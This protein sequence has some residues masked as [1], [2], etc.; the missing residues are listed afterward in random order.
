MG[1]IALRDPT[2]NR[3]IHFTNFHR[4]RAARRADGTADGQGQPVRPAAGQRWRDHHRS[5]TVTS[6]GPRPGADVP[7]FYLTDAAG[8]KRMRLLA[9]E[10][11]ELRPGESRRMTVSAAPRLLARF[12]SAA[13]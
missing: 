1:S 2:V 13:G 6:T 5:F 10:R 4:T 11:V 9:F 3:V 12:D 7:Q 8:E